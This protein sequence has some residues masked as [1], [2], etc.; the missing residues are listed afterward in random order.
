M[1]PRSDPSADR[2]TGSTMTFLFTDIEGSTRRWEESTDMFE[3]VS[4]HFSV[5]DDEVQLAG[6]TV[7][8]TLGDG[9][10]SAFRSAHAA[11]QAAVNAQRRLRDLGLGV[12]MG[13]HTGEVERAGADFR[14][15][16]VIARL[17][18]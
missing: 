4:R 7:F 11:V 1:D 16:T 15:R 10:A 13:L 17:A 5:L 9:I 12:R 8:A 2:A 18:S 14:G 3:L 6:G